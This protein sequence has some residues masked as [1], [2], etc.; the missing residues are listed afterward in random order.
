MSSLKIGVVGAG[1]QG[2]FHAEKYASLMDCKL[3]AI[4]D[5]HEKTANEVARF[6][7]D[8]EPYINHK[9]LLNI[10][11]AVS[12][13][14]CAGAH[15]EIAKDFLQ[16]GKHVLLE[17]PITSEQ[18]EAKHL[19]ELAEECGVILQIGHVERFNPA[20]IALN[21]RMDDLKFIE[22]QRFS[23]FRPRGT[24]VSVVLDLMIHDIDLILSLVNSNIRHIDSSGMQVLSDGVDIA[25]ARIIFENGCIANVTA[26]RVSNKSERKLRLFQANAYLSCDLG[27][28]SLKAYT[29]QDG[30][31]KPDKL[32]CGNQDA[33]LAQVSDFVRCIQSG[34][35]PLVSGTDGL[36]ALKTAHQISNTMRIHTSK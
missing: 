14:T 7:D 35:T 27:N 36:R 15:Y 16:H 22:A 24:D 26:S 32:L 20:V 12:I 17:K 5:I 11:D 8:A 10:V 18:A 28:R 19:I 25:N 3:V 13:A 23:P 33:L 6:Y 21:E 4:A 2:R 31:I 1:H 9:A 34:A 30:E 29:L